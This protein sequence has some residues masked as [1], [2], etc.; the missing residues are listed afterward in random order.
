MPRPAPGFQ[1][2]RFVL[3]G[4]ARLLRFIP[5]V[6]SEDIAL[7][8]PGRPVAIDVTFAPARENA[9]GRAPAVM[10]WLPSHLAWGRR[11]AE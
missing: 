6:T 10:S 1:Q 2:L 3:Q 7:I 8:W 9:S 11:A 4:S 5:D